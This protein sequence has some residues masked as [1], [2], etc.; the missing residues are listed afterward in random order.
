MSSN[1]SKTTP[2]SAMVFDY[3]TIVN[4]YGINIDIDEGPESEQEDSDG[5]VAP[6]NPQSGA[7]PPIPDLDD[8][9]EGL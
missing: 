2:T 6:L 1:S 9:P 5:P 3:D 4:K 7:V 8:I